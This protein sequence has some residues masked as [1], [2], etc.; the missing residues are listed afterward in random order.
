MKEIPL[1]QCNCGQATVLLIES[2]LGAY[3]DSEEGHVINPMMEETFHA[4]FRNVEY[5]CPSDMGQVEDILK[6]LKEG[7]KVSKDTVKKVLGLAYDA[8]DGCIKEARKS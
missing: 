4:V 6:T 3:F 7:T 1:A 2:V 8:F 5:A